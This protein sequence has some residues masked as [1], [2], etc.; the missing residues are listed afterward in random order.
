MKGK[1]T[2]KIAPNSKEYLYEN[3]TDAAVNCYEHKC[4]CDNCLMKDICERQPKTNAYNMT[5]M[6]FV[7]LKL[8]EHKGKPDLSQ[9][10]FGK[11]NVRSLE[12]RLDLSLKRLYKKTYK[13]KK[14]KDLR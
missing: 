14:T 2:K 7:V 10:H 1:D 5:P 4:I 12:Q 3:W 8:L 6:K 13:K 9:L 11:A